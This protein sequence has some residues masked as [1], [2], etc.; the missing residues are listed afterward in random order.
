MRALAAL[1]M[2][3]ASGGL[4]GGGD[5]GN[6]VVRDREDGKLRGGTR[7][8]RRTAYV[9]HVFSFHVLEQILVRVSV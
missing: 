8:P 3:W 9:A 4:D 6:D 7:G 5:V 1:R 2:V